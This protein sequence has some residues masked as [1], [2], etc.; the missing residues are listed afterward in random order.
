MA[1]A[2]AI[3]VEL[4]VAEET[5]F[6]TPVFPS[7]TDY[8]AAIATPTIDQE[9]ELLD[10]EEL[11]NTRSRRSPILG[12]YMPGGWSFNTYIKPS[13]TA[14]TAP[15][16]D[17]LWKC[18]LGTKTSAAAYTRYTP[19]HTLPSFTLWA[20]M[21]HTVFELIG[22]TVNEVVSNVSGSEIGTLNW[23]G[24]YARMIKSGYTTLGDPL[25]GGYSINRLSIT[26]ADEFFEIG[27]VI[28]VG[29]YNNSGSG[30][31]VTEVGSD[32]V[33]ITPGISVA[34]AAGAVV[35]GYLPAGTA[36]GTP[37]HGTVG[38]CTHDGANFAILRSVTTINNNIQYMIDEKN[39]TRYADD[40]VE[41][42]RE[43]T[44]TIEAYF[45]E[46]GV[47]R[48]FEALDRDQ[49]AFI[50]PC[51]TTAGS[52]FELTMPYIELNNPTL[53]G[54]THLVQTLTGRA[55]ASSSFDDEIQV[56]YE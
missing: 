5:I 51:G 14:G 28:Y 29:D 20:R 12:R 26:N 43:V 37:Q 49:A 52:I 16:T 41:L 33:L 50:I 6:N 10:N 1:I 4:F 17:V 45:I 9:L 38:Y 7:S 54:D 30:Y 44:F 34:V 31:T 15:E 3:E 27:S 53:A 56:D 35:A 21:G 11:I 48:W 42:R 19:A 36:V 8:V 46:A 25:A 18:A 32:Y 39:S 22:A 47:N 13:G 23:S 24:G 2:R 40:Y 55:I